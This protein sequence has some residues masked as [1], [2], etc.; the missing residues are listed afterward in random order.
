[1]RKYTPVQLAE[2]YDRASMY[3]SMPLPNAL[4]FLRRIPGQV[5]FRE[6][7]MRNGLRAYD[8]PSEMEQQEFGDMLKQMLKDW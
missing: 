8:V 1:M 7:P 6:P 2:L 5:Y 3:K 4:G